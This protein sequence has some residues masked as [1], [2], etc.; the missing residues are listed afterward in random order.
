MTL[1]SRV[2]VLYGGPSSER[3]ISCLSTKS[4]TGALDELGVDYQ[5]IDIIEANWMELLKAYHPDFVFLGLHGCPG[6]DGTVQGALELMGY[7]YQGSGVLSSS[8]AIHKPTAKKV[9]AASHID[10]A[11]EAVYAWNA[12]PENAAELYVDLPVV[13][14]PVSGGSSVG[15]YIVEDA[16][17][18]PDVR[19]KVIQSKEI[20][21]VE[22]YIA[23]REFTVAVMGDEALGVTEIFSNEHAFYDFDSKYTAGGSTH[24]C[25]ADIPRELAEK[26]CEIGLKAHQA[27]DC[28]GVTRS[29]LRYDSAT[30]RLVILELNTLP[31]MTNV[32]LVP[33]LAAYKGYSFN[34]L[35]RW[36]IED[37]ACPVQQ[38]A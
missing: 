7:P 25:P 12:L 32:S 8:L 22:E 1:P 38:T 29:D 20:V 2:A 37:A 11:A 15:I 21:M 9:F 18:W 19:S 17:S 30:G 13:V 16:D 28:K 24:V 35:I 27:L 33:E 14:K 5:T 26:M 23:G 36:M 3:E 6:E 34:Q 10:V 31:G 4:V